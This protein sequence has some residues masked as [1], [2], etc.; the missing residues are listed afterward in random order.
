MKNNMIVK[1]YKGVMD[2]DLSLVDPKFHKEVIKQHHTDIKDYKIDQKNRL[3]KLRYENA[4]VPAL[5][6]LEM[7]RK[8]LEK[9]SKEEQEI[10]KRKDKEREKIFYEREKHKKHD[11]L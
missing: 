5:K 9:R 3:P 10:L 1:G 11:S 8:A 6:V 2:L 7:E 4:T